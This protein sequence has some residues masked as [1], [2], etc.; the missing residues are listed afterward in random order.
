MAICDFGCALRLAGQHIHRDGWPS[1]TMQF[2]RADHQRLGAMLAQARIERALKQV[3]LAKALDIPQKTISLI[4]SGRRRVD[5][6]EL[7]AIER[8][9]GFGPLVL[10]GQIHKELFLRD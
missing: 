2:D 1:L 7:M 5:A 10:I 4:E 3:D 9:I 8:A 6:L